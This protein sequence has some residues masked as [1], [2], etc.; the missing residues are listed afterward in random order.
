MSRHSIRI[1]DQTLVFR[2][3]P[4]QQPGGACAGAFRS[5]VPSSRIWHPGIALLTTAESALGAPGAGA[6][7]AKSERTET[8]RE[9]RRY[10]ELRRGGAESYFK[11]AA[12]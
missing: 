4:S 5:L 11:P 7:R 3:S 6:Q 8:G 1:L 12:L 9:K 2:L 10:P